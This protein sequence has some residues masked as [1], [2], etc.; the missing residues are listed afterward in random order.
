MKLILKPL[1]RILFAPVMVLLAFAIWLC[2]LA[3]TISATLMHLVSILFV[4]VSITH[5]IEHRMGNGIIGLVIA[6][7]LSPY[8]LPMIAAWLIAQLHI[9]RDWMKETI[10]W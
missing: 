3:V 7:L 2:T 4:V 6:F 10:Y 5:F 8:G 1:L 9:F